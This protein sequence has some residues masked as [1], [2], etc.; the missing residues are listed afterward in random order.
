MSVVDAGS[1]HDVN[2]RALTE[3]MSI[4]DRY[5]K[6]QVGSVHRK[7]LQRDDIQNVE[8]GKVGRQM[9]LKKSRCG[10]IRNIGI[11]DKGRVTGQQLYCLKVQ[12]IKKL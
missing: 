5:F 6:A 3:R 7:H 2:D 9:L 11:Q 8:G 1:Q 10:S 12:S 4:S